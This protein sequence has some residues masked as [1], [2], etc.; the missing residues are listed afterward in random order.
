M[1]EVKHHD[2]E[3]GEI[4]I[5]GRRENGMCRFEVSDD[6]PGIP[7]GYRDKIFRLFETLK[8]RD[9]VE[10]S[11]MGLALVR[12][13]IEFE[14]GSIEL[15]RRDGRGAMFRLDWPDNGSEAA[16]AA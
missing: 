4:T 10:G 14:G 13:M 11:G 2:A 7:S 1:N 6:G 8:S 5:R 16:R 3:R 12:K 9:K 15:V